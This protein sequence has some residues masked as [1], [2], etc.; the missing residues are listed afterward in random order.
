MSNEVE[1]KEVI[2]TRLSR[3][4]N[5]KND[6]IRIV[7]EIWD[8]KTGEKIAENDPEIIETVCIK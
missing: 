8:A 6:P 7:L 2:I 1:L 3:R 4:G 5:G